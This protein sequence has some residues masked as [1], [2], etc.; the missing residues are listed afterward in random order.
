MTLVCV[1]A[2]CWN[3]LYEGECNMKINRVMLF[4]MYFY[5]TAVSFL[6]YRIIIIVGSVDDLSDYF[7]DLLFDISAALSILLAIVIVILLIFSVFQSIKLFHKNETEELRKQMK[8]IKFSMIPFYVINF[9]VFTFF[10]MLLFAASRGIIIFTPFMI[11][12]L[13]QIGFTYLTV[14]GTSSYGMLFAYS[15]YKNNLTKLDKSILLVIL[16][17]LFVLDIVATIILLK[18]KELNHIIS[19]KEG[20]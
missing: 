16:Q 10:F 19:E 2:D 5:L 15:N 4:V 11:P 8:R 20:S 6:I 14:V 3:G 13:L 7:D 17:L 12:F 9:G 1:R 18:D